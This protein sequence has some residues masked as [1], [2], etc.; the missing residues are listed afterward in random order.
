[1]IRES[2]F[3]KTWRAE[4]EGLDREGFEQVEQGMGR[5]S[6]RLWR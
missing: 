5:K 2:D 3:V 4:I 6:A 1:M